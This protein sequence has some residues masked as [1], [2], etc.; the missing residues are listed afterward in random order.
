MKR[1]PASHA[2]LPTI[3]LALCLSAGL[4]APSPARADDDRYARA[5]RSLSDADASCRE[6][7]LAT[8]FRGYL[9]LLREFPTWWLPTLK[10]GVIAR[11]QGLP[12]ETVAA[13][14]ERARN[15]SP[16]GA[17]L[18][19]IEGFLAPGV[20]RDPFRRDGAAGGGV[21]DPLTDRVAL[22]RAGRLAARGRVAEAEAEYRA[23]LSRTPSI[24]VARWRLARLLRST[25]RPVE[26]A[27]LF[28]EGGARSNLPSRWRVEAA[29]V[30]QSNGLD[31]A[32]K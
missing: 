12:A 26:A 6:G 3:L 28:R 11:A 19:L 24:P 29:V 16:T 14:V 22:L 25:G 32:T 8:A 27:A 5:M 7:R 30:E 23:I 15:L 21:V 10:A 31:S 17:Y 13:W 18:P 4:L 9:D 2:P 1:P 20:P